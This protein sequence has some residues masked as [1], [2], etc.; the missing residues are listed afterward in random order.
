MTPTSGHQADVPPLATEMAHN[1]LLRWLILEA[2]FA[3]TLSFV[4]AVGVVMCFVWLKPPSLGPVSC[5]IM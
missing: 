3:T 5:L 1:R 2:T 4:G